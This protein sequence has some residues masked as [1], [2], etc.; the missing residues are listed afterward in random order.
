MLMAAASHPVFF[1]SVKVFFVSPEVFCV[2]EGL[3]SGK[4][5][6]YDGRA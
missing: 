3:L 5:V 1:V 2:C 6:F 4:R